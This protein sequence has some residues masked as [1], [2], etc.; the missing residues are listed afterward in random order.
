MRNLTITGVLT[1]VLL[2]FPI[3]GQM[4]KVD[5]M[6]LDALGKIER[7]TNENSQVMKT[8]S[9]LTDVYGGRLTGSPNTRL[10][11]DW[12]EKKMKEWG[13]SN[14]HEET[15]D[16]EPGGWVNERLS[17]NVISPVTYPLIGYPLAWTRGT[18]GPVTAEAV[19]VSIRQEADFE[20]YHGKLKGKIVLWQSP[21]QVLMGTQPL[22]Y[23]CTDEEL[24]TLSRPSSPG[25][26]PFHCGNMGLPN[27]PILPSTPS[28]LSVQQRI[29]LTSKLEE[30]LVA[31][32]VA[33]VFSLAVGPARDGTVFVTSYFSDDGPPQIVL[34]P[35]HYNRI[36]R[37]LQDGVPVTVEL[38][39][40]NRFLAESKKSFNII[41]EIPGSDPSLADQMVMIGGHFDSWQAGTGATD[42]GVGAAAMM[43]VMRVLN[44]SGLK[45]RRTIRL[46]LWTSEEESRRGSRAYVAE[47]YGDPITMNLK[48]DHKKFDVYFNIDNGSGKIRGVYLEGNEAAGTV[49][50][51]W[52]EPFESMGM[53]TL[54]PRSEGATD[55]A[56]FNEI[57][58]PGFQ[59]IQDPLE[60]NTLTH[61]SN[62]DVYERVQPEDVKQIVTVVAAFA[63]QAANRDEMIPRKALPQAKQ[64]GR[65]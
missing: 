34:T 22:A 50:K 54:S 49:F 52:M 12:S 55:H 15:F 47:H 26:P 65:I 14:V 51:N 11:A 60:Y 8:L 63:Y 6:D 53:S 4:Q 46:G 2:A 23:R 17:A 45:F 29:D 9:Y 19:I 37:T 40:Q 36:Y 3:A 20:K 21:V 61:H 58:L 39:V 13:L 24:A 56:S 5:R 48:P 64:G 44:A 42:N 7:E 10:A 28:P 62:M 30:F 1:M 31:Q 25:E 35:E 59:F 16:F 43:E 57:G 41:A 33:A 32:G 27:R 38:N 18:D